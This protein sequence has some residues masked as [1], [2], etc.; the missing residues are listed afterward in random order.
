MG[1]R[2]AGRGTLPSFRALLRGEVRH[3]AGEDLGD[4]EHDRLVKPG[5][6]ADA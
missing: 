4:C 6:D 2:A 1:Q 3:A 5:S